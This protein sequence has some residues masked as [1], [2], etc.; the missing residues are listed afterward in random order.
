M[1]NPLEAI[2][3]KSTGFPS[4]C[5]T[6]YLQMC[7]L[8][9]SALQFFRHPLS[10]LLERNTI[11]QRRKGNFYIVLETNDEKFHNR[12]GDTACNGTLEI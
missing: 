2:H 1:H 10:A 6:S 8:K 11:A 4:T 7:S 5:P 9:F 3:K 12:C